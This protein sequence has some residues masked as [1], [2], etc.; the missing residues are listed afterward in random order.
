MVVLAITVAWQAPFR[1]RRVR[2]PEVREWIVLPPAADPRPRPHSPA[3][4]DRRVV[5]MPRVVPAPPPPDVPLRAPDRMARAGGGPIV[6]GPALGD[7]SAW[8]SPRPALAADVAEQLYGRDTTARD[9]QVRERL[10]AMLD[11]LNRYLDQEQRARRRP[12]W[13]TDVAGIPFSIDS[14]FIN[15]AGF[16]IPSTVLAL[17]GNLLPPGNYEE[18]LRVRQFTDMRDDML[19]A[20]QRA[21][22]FRDF[23]KYVK[24]L[25]ARKQAERDSALARVKPP[26]DTTRFIP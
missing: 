22:T 20:A 19:R 1:Q 2:T 9:A 4:S 5:I 10:H 16:K 17:F 15:I 12:T 18:A 24:E 13:S 25:R 7:G 3:F 14:Q 23:Q 8:P 26:A 21:E 6:F 11:S